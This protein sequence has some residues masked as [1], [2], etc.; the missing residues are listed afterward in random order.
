MR[1]LII[2]IPLALL[3][4]VGCSVPSE[5][6]EIKVVTSV[7][8]VYD[9]TQRLL[10]DSAKA[11]LVVPAGSDAHSF[12]PTPKD[13]AL[14]Q[15]ADVFVYHGAGL[16]AWVDSVLDTLNTSD[17]IILNLSES[18]HLIETEDSNASHNDDEHNH[19]EGGHNHGIYDVHSWLS[20]DNARSQ[21][22][23]IAET[24]LAVDFEDKS[25]IET[26]L[27]NALMEFDK[28]ENE[29]HVLNDLGEHV[30]FLVDH[31]AY[32]Y[33]AHDY[34]LHQLS[35]IQG[36]LS[37]EP[38]AKD[39]ETSIAFIQE[40]DIEAIFVNPN[41]SLK[42]YDIIKNETGVAIYPLHTLETLTK[43]EMDQGLDYFSIMRI[44]LDSLLKGLSHEGHTH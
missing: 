36:V 37:E 26:N 18:S 15:E 2:I 23:K 13:I 21:T 44:N 31:K 35:I 4:L 9:L 22:K 27:N 16:E 5:N 41:A 34:N 17:M 30:D 40:H 32:G 19:D 3:L 24:L 43:A 7:Y 8:P 25:I 11:H 38:T 14:I 1:R 20:I 6:N 29:Y 28:L 42:V 10:G 39:I 12:E 33:L